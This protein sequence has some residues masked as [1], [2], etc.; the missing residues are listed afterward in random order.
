VFQRVIR[1]DMVTGD[2][3]KQDPDVAASMVLGIVLQVID[4]QPD[5]GR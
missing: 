5:E 4:T 2:I 3:P 1:E